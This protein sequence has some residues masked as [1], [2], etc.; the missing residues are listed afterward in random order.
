MSGIRRRK[1]LKSVAVGSGAVLAG[2][3]LP[4]SWLKPVVNSVFLPSHAATSCMPC[5][6]AAS[7]CEG[8]G[9]GS[10]EVSVAVD[11]TVTLIH[12]IGTGTDSVDICEGGAFSI[13]VDTPGAG[14]VTV[15]GTIPCGATDSI[16]VTAV[17]GLGSNPLTL[18]KNLCA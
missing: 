17:D 4:E 13:T 11:G 8:R 15:S 6:D 7:Y 10:M 14:T 2:K 5:L 9:Q 18:S 1:I 12:N 3:T 16:S